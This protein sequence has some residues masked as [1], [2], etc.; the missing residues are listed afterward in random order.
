MYPNR[1]FPGIFWKGYRDCGRWFARAPD[2]SESCCG[3]GRKVEPGIWRCWPQWIWRIFFGR[4]WWC[5][6]KIVISAKMEMLTGKTWDF[7]KNR[8]I[9]SYTTV[10]STSKKGDFVGPEMEIQ[11]SE[12]GLPTDM[13]LNR[14]KMAIKSAKAWEFHQIVSSLWIQG[15][16]SIHHRGGNGI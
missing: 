11:P 7:S 5:L 13:I 16:W 14:P 12:A 1:D 3:K 8:W 10:A 6:H 4:K 2:T 15:G 9:C